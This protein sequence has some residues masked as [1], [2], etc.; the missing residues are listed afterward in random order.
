[1]PSFLLCVTTTCHARRYIRMTG[2]QGKAFK[3][4]QLKA[5]YYTPFRPAPTHLVYVA[6]RKPVYRSSRATTADLCCVLWFTYSSGSI[7][8]RSFVL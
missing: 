5:P 3:L 2:P 1:M 8:T 4:I 6:L 7:N